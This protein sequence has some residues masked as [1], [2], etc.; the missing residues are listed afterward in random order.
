[1]TGRKNLIL[2]L[3]KTVM[4]IL[5][6]I[7]ILLGLAW[8]I[9][10]IT[11]VPDFQ[12]TR[13]MLTAAETMQIDEY[14]GILYPVVLRLLSV[15][16]GGYSIVL[17]FLQMILAVC[18]YYAFLRYVAG[19]FFHKKT[20]LLWGVAAYI[21]TFP[22]ILQSHLCVLPYSFATSLFVFLITELKCLLAQK[23]S[24]NILRL[25]R[26]GLLWLT[27]GLLIPDY[28]VITGFVV[29]PAFVISA[30]K[31]RK[32]ILLYLLTVILVVSG[33]YGTLAV[34]QTPGSYGRMQKSLSS[35]LL[36]RF[37]W[38]YFGRDSYY[39][40]HRN[41]IEF[42]PGELDWISMYPEYTFYRFGPKVE[43]ILGREEANAVYAHMAKS[44][45]LIGKK[46]ALSALGRDTLAN[47]GGPF[48]VQYQLSGRGVSYTG[49][50]YY[51]MQV[52]AP[53][54]AN[55]FVKFSLYTFDFYVL[56]ALVAAWRKKRSRRIATVLKET[57]FVL[58]GLGVMILWYTMTGNGM[59]D[60]LKV[61]PV[62][63]FWCMLP[64]LGGLYETDFLE[65]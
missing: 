58:I 36:T 15:L 46:E 10:N 31:Q 39:W 62:M 3:I 9:C 20:Y 51:Q 14:M 26:I 4:L 53:G 16:G 13:D 49:W 43:N 57:A 60:Y 18:S 55:Y 38:P 11:N 44:S 25:V 19:A 28:G 52:K 42:E 65:C 8:I 63:I 2:N 41:W 7:Q 35:V 45:F 40:I 1:M 22:M 21:A 34:T 56:A 6:A 54:L 64:V 50:N 29:V 12:E 61:I 24:V 5:G 47:A 33:M 23:E 32:R 48:A 30:W 37:T 27:V 59:Q 17:Y